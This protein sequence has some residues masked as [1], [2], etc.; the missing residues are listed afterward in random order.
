MS[1]APSGSSRVCPYCHLVQENMATHVAKCANK[2]L[3]SLPFGDQSLNLNFTDMT[4][5]EVVEIFSRQT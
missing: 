1:N 4:D 3:R 5:D 2:P